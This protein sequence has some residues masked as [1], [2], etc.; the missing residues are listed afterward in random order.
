MRD[1]KVVT[2]DELQRLLRDNPELTPEQIF[3]KEK[4]D[5]WYSDKKYLADYLAKADEDEKARKEAEPPADKDEGK[6]RDKSKYLDPAQNPFIRLNPDAPTKPAKP[7][8]VSK[9]LD[10]KQNP[11]L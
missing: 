9:Y 11:F 10:P 4:M 5:R 1:D 3:G 6:G 2:L 7:E 8:P